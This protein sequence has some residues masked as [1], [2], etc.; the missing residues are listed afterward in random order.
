MNA[1]LLVLPQVIL[2][3]MI[4]ISSIKIISAS[5][6]TGIA[7]PGCDDHCGDIPIPFPF[8]TRD[9]CYLNLLFRVVCAYPENTS[10]P[11]ELILWDI[12][13]NG[14]ITHISLEGQLT[15]LMAVNRRCYNRSSELTSD[16]L[17]P[18]MR[19]NAPGFTINST[20]NMFTVVGCSDI[21]FF[22]GSNIF[23][24]QKYR[25]GCM[26]FC[27]SAADVI[28]GSC[29]G[30]G[31]CQ[32]SIPPGQS[33]VNISMDTSFGHSNVSDFN[34]CG[35][36][37]VVEKE[38]FIFSSANLTN[39]IEVT[40]LPMVIDWSILDWV[41]TAGI[42][43]WFATA[44]T[45]EAARKNNTLYACKGNTS[46]YEPETTIGYR[47]SCLPGYQGNP[48][49]DGIDGCTDIDE[50][51]DN[52]HNC[53]KDSACYNIVGSHECNCRKGYRGDGRTDGEGCIHI[54]DDTSKFYKLVT[55][56]SVGALC[57]VIATVW[58]YI[59]FRR[60][61]SMVMRDKFFNDNGGMLLKQQL[62]T[63]GSGNVTVIFSIHELKI[64]TNN[65]DGNKII[66][67]GGF[68][69]VY[70]G[71]LADNREVAIK[72]SKLIDRTQIGTFINEVI[73]LSQ[74]NHRNI[75]KLLG[76]CLESE[77]PLLV[78]EFI[79]NGTLF[80]HIHDTRTTSKLS[81]E[82]RLRIALETA[83]V[84][85]YLHSVASPPI[86]HRDI[87]SRNILLDKNYTA[88][89][90]DFGAS[91]LVPQ[92]QAQIST[93]VQGTFG[94]LDPEYMQTSKLTE[95]SDVYSF[96]VLLVE[97]LTSMKVV[98]FDRPEEERNLANYFLSILKRKRLLEILDGN[99][100]HEM[101]VKLLEEV[102]N[103]AKRC[104]KVKGE[105]RPTMKEVAMELE[106]TLKLSKLG[107]VKK[108]PKEQEMEPLLV[109]Q[110][111][112]FGF[113]GNENIFPQGDMSEVM[114]LENE[115]GR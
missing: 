61:K 46:C 50:C 108:G 14:S 49:L 66:G 101:N 68:G 106:G 93:M 102:A 26:T 43:D 81:L 38:A 59:W 11:P 83:G 88:K 65:F 110:S 10:D 15:L 39:M 75:V 32:A 79:E 89:V 96:G 13:S 31:C 105:D 94:Y 45:C 104:L 77:I 21:A 56:A 60:R 82:R 92:D 80:E 28:N 67:E 18:W 86:I 84:L 34:P 69:T 33:G 9:G 44:R 64:A 111:R 103:L 20:A 53:A 23:D 42:V 63:Q 70:H 57:I 85:S 4:L 40:R 3:L 37:F 36:A 71:F 29:S 58:L 41:L 73:V 12:N 22:E 107:K 35:Y 113:V 91:R 7:K 78:Y 51:Q 1:W 5:E 52:I 87:K 16:L 115:G 62:A 112:S 2:V 25:T 54:A 19:L 17:D 8:G 74:V 98:S 100:V 55:G 24:S 90:S 76:C 30:L 99:I 114:H 27:Q 48:Y 109:V 97:L 95:K 6:K 72:K 47:C